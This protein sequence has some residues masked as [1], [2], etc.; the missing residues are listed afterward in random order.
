MSSSS[1]FPLDFDIKSLDQEN[2]TRKIKLLPRGETDENKGFEVDCD[3]TK[4]SNLI[5]TMVEGDKEATFVNLDI[6]ST[7]LSY[8][9][10]WMNYKKG[11]PG[12]IV[13]K[14]LKRTIRES[15]VDKWDADFIERVAKNKKDLHD[16][17]RAANYLDMD[18]LLHLAGAYIALSLRGKNKDE[19]K[20]ILA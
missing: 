5:N 2:L 10:E 4:I 17:L 3:Y 13:P 1:I 8:I 9:V 12:V 14:P 19:M 20:K 16:V 7:I 11:N 15:C 18:T 6:S